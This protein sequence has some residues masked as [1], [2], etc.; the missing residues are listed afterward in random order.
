ML[1]C[2]KFYPD[3]MLRILAFACNSLNSTRTMFLTMN[4]DILKS[5]DMENVL[6]YWSHQKN[7]AVPSSQQKLLYLANRN[8]CDLRTGNIPRSLQFVFVLIILMFSDK[9]MG[10]C[11]Q[12]LLTSKNTKRFVEKNTMIYEVI[13]AFLKLYCKLLV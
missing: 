1:A 12:I 8:F 3:A 6:T 7:R 4:N 9:L 2:T 11:L 13:V 5:L 10:S